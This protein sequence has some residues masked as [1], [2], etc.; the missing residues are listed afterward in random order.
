[1]DTIL[2]ADGTELASACL[3]V[4]SDGDADTK[5]EVEQSS[6]EDIIRFTIDGNE[7]AISVC[8]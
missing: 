1:M 6:D 2:F 5:I 4:L 8:Q 3:Q 7:I